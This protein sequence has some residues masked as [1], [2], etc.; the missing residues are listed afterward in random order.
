MLSEDLLRQLQQFGIRRGRDLPAPLP[1]E[2]APARSVPVEGRRVD[3]G[4]GTCFLVEE[5]YAL[6]HR[7]GYADLGSLLAETLSEVAGLATPG[8]V[9]PDPAGL[10]FLDIETTGLADGAGTYAFLVGL[11][12]FVDDTFQL[13]QVFM[14]SPAE[15]R[16]LLRTVGDLLEGAEGLVTFNGRAFDLPIL[17]TRHR[18][19]RMPVPWQGWPNLDLLLPSRRLFRNRLE[20]CSLSSLEQHLLGVERSFLDIPGWRIPSVY[21]DYLRGADPSVLQPIFY[22]NSYDILS[23]VILA[24]RLAR[25]LRDPFGEGGARQGLEFYALGSLYEQEGDHEVAVS[26]YR[27]ALLLA[28]PLP[29]RERTWERLTALLKR[30]GAWTEVVEIWEALVER[31]GDHPLYA[32]VELAKYYEHHHEDL[33]RAE[34]LVCRA[35]DEHGSCPQGEDLAHRLERLRLKRTRREQ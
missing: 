12:R 33:A 21:H 4:E 8:D 27:A 25:F 17:E 30:Q 24:T 19:A 32:Y 34:S 15:E 7:H 35:I 31:P 16:A 2:Q 29:M 13:Y 14:R 3:T 26:A 11:G 1:A 9:V 18:L 20:S 28:M 10:A 6:T 23:M 22:H 5:A